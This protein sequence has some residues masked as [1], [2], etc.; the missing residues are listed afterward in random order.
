MPERTG[1]TSARR[2]IL[3]VEDSDDFAALVAAQLAGHG[4]DVHHSRTLAEA[5]HAADHGSFAG[6]FV[7]LDLPDA[8][9]LEA[10]M[11]IRHAA[12]DLPLIV[13]SGREIETA[14]VKAVLLGAQDWVAKHEVTPERLV[15]TLDLAIARQDAQAREVWKAAHDDVTG[16]P[17]RTL[18]LEHLG[19]ALGR[20]HRRGER[21]AVLFCDLDHFKGVNDGHGHAAGDAVLAQVAHRL[22]ATVRPG[23]VVAR[24]GGDEFLVVAEA[25]DGDEQALAVAARIRA[26][27][28]EPVAPAGV[29]LAV[30]VTLGV[31]VTATSVA[32]HELIAAADDAMLAAK[33]DGRG[34]SLAGGQ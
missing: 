21:V 3:H 19:R 28:A 13:L 29:D 16:L 14:P 11:G 8:G 2:V 7:D 6:A 27:V 18:A 26:R 24:W 32:P 20:A 5:R 15:R 31:A 10:V 25:I 9:G 33:R 30:S 34:V 23:D 12:P 1:T 22:V 17:N 4:V